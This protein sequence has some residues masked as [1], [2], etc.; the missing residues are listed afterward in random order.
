MFFTKLTVFFLFLFCRTDV[1]KDTSGVNVSSGDLALK[2]HIP[3]GIYEVKLP[4]EVSLVEGS[5]QTSPELNEEELHV[6][7]RLKVGQCSGMCQVHR[8]YELIIFT[9]HQRNP[10]IIMT[11]ET[12]VGQSW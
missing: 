6:R 3:D 8:G 10:Y 4:P 5:C 11:T 1:V 2:I 7:V 12:L 9:F